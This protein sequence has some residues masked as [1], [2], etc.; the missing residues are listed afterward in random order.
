MSYP[1]NN[2]YTAGGGMFRG[3]RRP[4]GH[5]VYVQHVGGIDIHRAHNRDIEDIKREFRNQFLRH[6]EASMEVV[7]TRSTHRHGFDVEV[8]MPHDIMMPNLHESGEE[9]RMP[10]EFRRAPNSV[11]TG[12]KLKVT[13]PIPFYDQLKNEIKEWVKMKN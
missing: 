6:L 12:T 9:R 11:K 7:L 8:F 5:R 1:S 13:A 2:T 4:D 3:D 10:E